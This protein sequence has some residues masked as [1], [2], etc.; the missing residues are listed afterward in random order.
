MM[1]AVPG[2]PGMM[3][4]TAGA[5]SNAIVPS[6]G[7]PAAAAAAHAE[8]PPQTDADGKKR[9]RDFSFMVTRISRSRGRTSRC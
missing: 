4:Q 1:G 3:A 8:P 5:S 7:S 9:A 6:N 2:M